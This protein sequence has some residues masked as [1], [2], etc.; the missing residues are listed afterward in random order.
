VPCSHRESK[1]PAK[2][3]TDARRHPRW[4]DSSD[5]RSSHSARSVVL[6]NPA[7]AD[8]SVNRDSAAVCSRAMS[9]GRV[10]S[11]R[12]RLRQIQL[13]RNH[14]P[15]HRA[16]FRWATCAGDYVVT[17][18]IRSTCGGRRIAQV[19]GAMVAGPDRKLAEWVQ[20]EGFPRDLRALGPLSQRKVPS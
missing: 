6:P 1:V 12:C 18:T 16:S 13:H 10:T 5:V 11:P 9:L 15:C 2:W 20:L 7:G 3:P 17:T 8:T 4:R 14:R 19:L